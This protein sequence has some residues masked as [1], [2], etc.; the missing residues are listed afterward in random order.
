MVLFLKCNRGHAIG[1]MATGKQ[2]KA[3]D[4]KVQLEDGLTKKNTQST[5]ISHVLYMYMHHFGTHRCFRAF[6]YMARFLMGW[7][8]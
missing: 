4:T 2:C 5:Y 7:I 6:G 1:G 3:S 8:K